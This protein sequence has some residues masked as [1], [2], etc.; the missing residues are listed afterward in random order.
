MSQELC[1]PLQGISPELATNLLFPLLALPHFLYA[2]IWL[3]SD[4][5]RGTFGERSV[6]VFAACGAIGKGEK[7]LSAYYHIILILPTLLSS[8]AIC[9]GRS[10]DL[11]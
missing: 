8:P 9:G 2:F 7:V 11:G 5:W 6:S 10:L 1:S 3:Q 4:A